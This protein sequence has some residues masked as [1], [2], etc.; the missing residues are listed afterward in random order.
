MAGVVDGALHYVRSA[1]RRAGLTLHRYSPETVSEA[2]LQA[3]LAHHQIDL[4]IDVGANSGQY[5]IALRRAGYAGQ[6]LSFEPLR[7]AWQQC[8][9]NASRDS[10]WSVAPQMAL[11]ATEG[12]VEIHVASNSVSSSILPMHETH[13]AAA[14]DSSY[15]GIESA[16]LRRLDCVARETIEQAHRPFLKIDTQGY[17][18]EVLEGATDVLDRLWGIQLEISLTPLYEGSPTLVEILSFMEHRGFVPQAL[19]PGFSDLTSG[20]MLQVD[21]LFFREQAPSS[22]SG[23]APATARSAVSGRS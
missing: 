4:V 12:R 6:I 5:A 7:D 20:R 21:A 14:A 23:P 18:R 9:A 19:L 11:G 10:L 17:E 15:V 8:T 13:R 22:P 1:L 16:D 3:L 2:R